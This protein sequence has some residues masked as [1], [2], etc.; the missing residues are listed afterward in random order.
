MGPFARTVVYS[1][2][3]LVAC[4]GLFYSVTPS[5]SAYSQKLNEKQGMLPQDV[6]EARR[7]KEQLMSKLRS[8]AGLKP[9]EES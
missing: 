9:K 1:I 7:D 6:L 3:L 8:E 2:G 4:G 5:E